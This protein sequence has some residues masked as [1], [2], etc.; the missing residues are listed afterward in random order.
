MSN[1][2]QIMLNNPLQPLTLRHQESLN[3]VQEVSCNIRSGFNWALIKE[4]LIIKVM[5]LI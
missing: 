2:N 4:I 1:W 3:G 5:N